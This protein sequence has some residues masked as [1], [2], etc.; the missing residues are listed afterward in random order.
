MH[1]YIHTICV[2]ICICFH[3]DTHVQ[4]CGHVDA[5]LVALLRAFAMHAFINMSMYVCMYVYIY[6]YMYIHI[7]SYT[8]LCSICCLLSLFI[9]LFIS[10][11]VLPVN[12]SVWP[13]C[14]PAPPVCLFVSLSV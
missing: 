3:V 13:A 11:Y 6:I 1:I 7:H 10:N 14:L 8:C 9:Y 2:C 12:L 5:G 4:T